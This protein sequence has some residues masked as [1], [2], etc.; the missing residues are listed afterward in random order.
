MAKP[1]VPFQFALDVPSVIL[2]LK[3]LRFL[4]KELKMRKVFAVLLSLFM[5]ITPITS[6]FAGIIHSQEAI[7]SVIASNDRENVM[8]L[9]SRDEIRQEM[10]SLGVSPEDALRRVNS[11][12]DDE[13][14][15]L[16]QHLTDKMAG[17]DILTIGFFVFVVFV[18]TDVIGATDLFPFIKPVR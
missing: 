4:R 9:L 5:I 13:I 6:S 15:T 12:T 11:L 7:N 8:N 14:S 1:F 10:M 18:I 16:N 17:Q 2:L 3:L